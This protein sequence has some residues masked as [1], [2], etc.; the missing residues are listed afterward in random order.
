MD[1]FTPGGQALQLAVPGLVWPG[2]NY[3]RGI[4]GDMRTYWEAVVPEDS[5]PILLARFTKLNGAVAVQADVSSISLKIFDLD[6][7]S[8]SS[9][10]SST[11]PSV[12]GSVF[13]TL[14]TN[15]NWTRDD[16]G[17]NFS[18]Q[19]PAA[20]LTE[21]RRRYAAEVMATLVAGGTVLVGQWLLS[22]RELM[23]S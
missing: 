3:D 16:S 12:A 1:C 9:P 20:V 23:G 18:T 6:G 19:I 2:F 13:D 17:Y 4:E 8:P 15:S 10:V 11:A 21:G 14:Q 22:T 7:D 5:R